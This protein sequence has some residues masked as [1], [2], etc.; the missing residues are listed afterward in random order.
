MISRMV[1]ILRFA[2]VLALTIGPEDRAPKSQ[3]LSYYDPPPPGSRP[4]LA[5]EIESFGMPAI[6][7]GETAAS[8]PPGTPRRLSKTLT[9][10]PNPEEAAAP[11]RTQP[12]ADREATPGPSIPSRVFDDRV[13]SSE[14]P[15]PM[16]IP[17]ARTP[18]TP[19]RVT[20]QATKVLQDSISTLLGKRP[21]AEIVEP[22]R[23]VEAK[24]AKGPNPPLGKR[25]RPLNRSRVRVY[26]AH[27]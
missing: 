24:K 3:S 7:L 19:K 6:L 4:P 26:P 27:D 9:P 5:E 22:E 15:S 10:P 12:S 14:S 16:R 23:E 2:L 11:P 1:R 8:E 17:G 20:K 25:A 21:A 18:S 13:P